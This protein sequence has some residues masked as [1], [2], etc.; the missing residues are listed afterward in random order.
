MIA[1]AMKAAVAAD[2]ASQR[3]NIFF[4]V[5]IMGLRPL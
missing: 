3:L 4:A 2:S 1:T 5:M